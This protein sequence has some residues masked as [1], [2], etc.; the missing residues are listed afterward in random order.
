MVP[1]L[2][3]NF[4]C[5]TKA[6]AAR[7]DS[8]QTDSWGRFGP[9]DVA[10]DLDDTQRAAIAAHHVELVLLAIQ[11]GRRFDLVF[12]YDVHAGH[13]CAGHGGG[14]GGGYLWIDRGC[15]IGW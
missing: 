15:V 12:A 4:P 11:D 14:D 10:L 5:G 8:D 6:G 13:R 7:R 2:L 1:T 3:G 9:C